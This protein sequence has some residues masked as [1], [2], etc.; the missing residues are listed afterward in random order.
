MVFTLSALTCWLVFLFSPHLGSHV[1]KT[2]W[3]YLLMS[4]KDMSISSDVS[5]RQ[6]HSKVPDP[7]DL[8]VS[9]P[10]PPQCLLHHGCGTVCFAV[11]QPVY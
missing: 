6:S 8:T 10:P 11:G 5:K 2:S 7:L 3:V 1:G 9:L 4:L